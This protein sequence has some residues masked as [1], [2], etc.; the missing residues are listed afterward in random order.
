MRLKFLRSTVQAC[1]EY[2][3]S[4]CT[5]MY[6]MYTRSYLFM[7][8]LHPN[9]GRLLTN[10]GIVYVLFRDEWSCL[11]SPLQYF[12]QVLGVIL[13]I[14]DVNAMT[15]PPTHFPRNWNDSSSWSLHL[16]WRI[17]RKGCCWRDA[18]GFYPGESP[19]PGSGR[20]G[21]SWPGGSS[22]CWPKPRLWA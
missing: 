17:V 7:Y 18:T 20:T 6:V 5:R 16:R 22:A 4:M 9:S 15:P 2:V 21:T 3:V 19:A 1:P 13:T 10:M 12:G 14:F 8:M 11:P